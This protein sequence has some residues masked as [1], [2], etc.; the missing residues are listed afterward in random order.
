MYIYIYCV[1]PI[2]CGVA[3]APLWKPGLACF[4]F[5][6]PVFFF[7]SRFVF[8]LYFV[9]FVEAAETLDSYRKAPAQGPLFWKIGGPRLTMVVFLWSPAKAS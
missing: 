6:F 1:S 2:F 5:L 4:L 9:C 8:S 7:L 3:Q